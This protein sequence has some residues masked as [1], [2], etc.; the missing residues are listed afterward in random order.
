LKKVLPNTV[1]IGAQKAGTTALYN[2]ISQHPEVYGDQAMKDFPFFCDSRYFDKGEDW[3]AAR[4]SKWNGERIILHGYVHYLF[5]A[6]ETAARLKAFN[7]DL[8]LLVVLR[9]P[10]ERA[11]SAYLQARKTG[12]ELI[13][14][15]DTAIDYELSGNLHSFKDIANRSYISHGRYSESIRTFYKYF[16]PKQIKIALYDELKDNPEGSCREFFEFLSVDNNHISKITS[17]NEYGVP[18]SRLVQG[19]IRKGIKWP[20][21]REIIPINMRIRSR[22]IIRKINTR[23][24][25]KPLLESSTWQ[26]LDNLYK[27][28]IGHLESLLD[29]DLSSWRM[30]HP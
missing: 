24:G 17:D 5:F 16:D 2:W 3:F 1:L 6:K 19:L 29:K 28:E 21:I 8:K 11:Y 22:Q 13:P 23:K 14:S 25:E 4:F 27:T 18:K 30:Y 26:R 9:N 12:N 20:L 7:P 10:A 15:F